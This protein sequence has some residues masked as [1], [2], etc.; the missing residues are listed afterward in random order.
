MSCKRVLAEG[1]HSGGVSH[2]LCTH[3]FLDR[4]SAVPQDRMASQS[5][6]MA[7][8]L[9]HA[10]VLLD[11]LLCVV[12]FNDEAARLWRV[13]PSWVLGQSFFDEVAPYANVDTFRGLAAAHVRSHTPFTHSFQF[14]GSPRPMEVTLKSGQGRV[15]LVIKPPASASS[16]R[17][18][19]GAHVV[20]VAPLEPR[21]ASSNT[22]QIMM[23]GLFETRTDEDVTIRMVNPLL[24]VKGR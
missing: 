6:Q 3:C 20:P 12:A 1:S 2:G 24:K 22:M 13:L 17:S 16:P 14:P 15:A 11:G 10:T 4:F 18:R 19:T 21:A 8:L 23:E 9:P 5:Q 7:N